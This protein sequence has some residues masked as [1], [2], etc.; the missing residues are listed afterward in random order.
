M[1]VK[2]EVGTTGGRT[3]FMVLCL[4]ARKGS[5]PTRPLRHR[6]NNVI[7]YCSHAGSLSLDA[8]GSFERRWSIDNSSAHSSEVSRTWM[9]C[10]MSG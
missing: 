4:G 9:I 2:V 6:I 8:E 1:E 10:A 5:S 7:G 3:M